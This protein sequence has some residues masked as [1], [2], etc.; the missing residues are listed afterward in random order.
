MFYGD[1][2]VSSLG[3]FVMLSIMFLET[4]YLRWLI[5]A[6]FVIKHDF[7]LP[8]HETSVFFNLAS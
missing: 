5:L 8:E 7:F 3:I 2:T 1:F 4:V 6:I